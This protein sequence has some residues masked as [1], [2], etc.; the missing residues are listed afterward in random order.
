M[1]KAIVKDTQAIASKV[2]YRGNFVAPEQLCGMPGLALYKEPDV[3]RSEQA[4]IDKWGKLTG[5]KV[6]ER[7]QRRA[8]APSLIHFQ[9]SSSCLTSKYLT[10]AL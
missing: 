7:A 5:R 10:S 6:Q 8:Q 3:T 1:P 9:A 4:N 2:T